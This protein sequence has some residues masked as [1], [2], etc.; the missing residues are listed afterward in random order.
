MLTFFMGWGNWNVKFP[1]SQQLF[2]E[3]HQ[4]RQTHVFIAGFGNVIHYGL[5]IHNHVV[6]VGCQALTPLYQE[7]VA[8]AWIIKTKI[9]RKW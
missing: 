4:R 8:N 1:L 5:L 7:I 6:G 9:Y 2:F 3:C